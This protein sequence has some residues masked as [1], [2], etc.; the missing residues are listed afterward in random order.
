MSEATRK[1]K[2]EKYSELVIVNLPKDIDDF[3][4]YE[5]LN[6]W[7]RNDFLMTFVYDLPQFKSVL[8]NVDKNN[9]LTDKGYLYIAYPKTSSKKYGTTIHR[10]EIF[11]FLDVNEE[12]G[13]TGNL[14]IKF[15]S[16]LAFNDDFSMIGLKRNSTNLR[17]T[18]K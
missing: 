7:K 8:E 10:D 9:Y 13:Q 14:D 6:K 2:L 5:Y 11:P 17:K 15:S 3:K 16:L 1:L 4:D 12:T 18:K